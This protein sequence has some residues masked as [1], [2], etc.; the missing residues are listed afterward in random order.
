MAYIVTDD[1]DQY[2]VEHTTPPDPLLDAL[3]EET[4]ATLAAPG[5]LSGPVEGR[6]LETLVFVSG[7]RSV[8]EFGTY[9]GYSAISM[10]AA[11]PPD[12]RLVTLELSEKHAEVARRYVAQTPYGDRIEVVVGP[13][14]ESVA[15]LE[16]P[17]DLVFV[18]ADKE[19]YRAYYEAALE[20]LSERGL[21]VVDNTLWS[22]RVVGDGEPDDERTA[23]LREFNDFV[24]ADERVVCV[25]LTVRDGVTLIRRRR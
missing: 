17:F 18:D 9:S 14:L 13:A 8:L 4:R 2:A 20:R 7:A 25:M 1:I 24:R 16:G 3:E 5:M 12:G 19:S 23:A 22:G 10:A 11:L 6:F 15:R 21:I